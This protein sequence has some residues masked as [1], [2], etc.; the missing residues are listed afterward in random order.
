MIK[1]TLRR[2]YRLLSRPHDDMFLLL[3]DMSLLFVGLLL[4]IKPL[5]SKQ[6]T[7]IIGHGMFLSCTFCFNL[8][9]SYCTV[10]V[11]S[12]FLWQKLAGSGRK[13]IL[14]YGV[15]TPVI[16]SALRREN[17]D[18]SLAEHVKIPS[19]ANFAF[20]IYG[21]AYLKPN[22]LIIFLQYN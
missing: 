6:T 20:E 1:D 2:R 5:L 17:P 12:Y 22:L 18:F 14:D 10:T 15:Y 11:R 16:S 19:P 13:T 7:T 8:S 9:V 21:V 3:S 4:K